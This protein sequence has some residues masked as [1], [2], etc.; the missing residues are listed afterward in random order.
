MCLC[1]IKENEKP[2]NVD[3]LRRA[4]I[5]NPDGFG[6]AIPYKTG[7]YI[8]KGYFKFDEFIKQFELFQ[9]NKALIH[10][11]Y[12][13]KGK[14]N[15]Q[16]SQPI[17][18]GKKDSEFVMAHNGTISIPL[19]VDRSDSYQLT[20]DILNPLVRVYGFNKWLFEAVVTRFIGEKN[21]VAIMN[22]SGKFL[23]INK[24]QWIFEDGNWYSNGDYRLIP[25]FDRTWRKFKGKFIK[26]YF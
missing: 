16:N 13:T 15:Q 3:Y 11:R 24:N 19:E 6:F 17:G 8:S 21:K 26:R 14:V 12:A 23:I 25:Q 2:I 20:K 9:N 1:I 18:F 10:F 22:K 5:R 7:I 4:A